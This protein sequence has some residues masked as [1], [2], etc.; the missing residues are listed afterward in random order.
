MST[1][2]IKRA[3]KTEILPNSNQTA[4]IHKT[5]GVSRFLYNL[6][7]SE[8]QRDYELHNPD[9]I[10]E[11]KDKR[12]K[13]LEYSVKTPREYLEAIYES[14]DYS[15]IGYMDFS[16]WINNELIPNNPDLR[17]IKEVSS[18]SNK[19]ALNN[20]DKAFKEFFKG[21]KGYPRFKKKKDQDVKCYFPKNN[22]TDWEVKRNKIKI[23]TLGWVHLKE[24]GYIPS[25]VKISSGT[26]SQKGDRYFVS[27]LV[28]YQMD[29]S[30][31]DRIPYTGG[32]GVD[33]G[34]KKFVTTNRDDL[35]FDNINKTNEIRRLEKKLK[36]EQRKLSRKYESYKA[37][38][39]NLSKNR[40]KNKEFKMFI[41]S[42]A[43]SKLTSDEVNEKLENLKKGEPTKYIGK[44]IAKQIL[45]IQKIHMRLTNIRHNYVNYVVTELVKTKPKFITIEDLNV[46]GLMKNKH[47]S[48]AI[49]NQNFHRFKSVLTQKCKEW[50]IELRMVSRTYPSS[51]RCSNCGNIKTELKLKDR[52]Y[53]C[54]VCNL[55][56][57]RDKNAGVNLQKATKYKVLSKTV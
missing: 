37:T 24:Y 54:D 3:F 31:R 30:W 53:T 15:F 47:L 55:T 40:E 48:K 11:S 23:P 17:W 14:F 22:P 7:I 20:A 26:V 43:E 2:T 16:K 41:D 35:S 5:I 51:K 49:A 9:K 57:D 27:V 6:F 1:V 36:R 45:K 28:E 46:K 42:I 12:K 52:T 13:H 18:K 39:N 56:I 38:G 21:D 29:V 4:L 50:N 34:I 10:N 33:L 8:N 19:Q 25:S 32:I 44:N